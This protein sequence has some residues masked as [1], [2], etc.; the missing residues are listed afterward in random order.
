MAIIFNFVPSSYK[1]LSFLRLVAVPYEDLSIRESK[2]QRP[3]RNVLVR[4]TFGTR[5][6]GLRFRVS[7]MGSGLRF[8]DWGSGFKMRV[9]DST[10]SPR[11]CLREDPGFGIWGL[12][13]GDRH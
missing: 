13:L 7:G 2:G 5:L 3:K 8:G 11:T 12:V 4:V 1:V 10:A 6:W 9:Q